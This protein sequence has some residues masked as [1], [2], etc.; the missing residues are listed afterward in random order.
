MRHMNGHDATRAYEGCRLPVAKDTMARNFANTYPF[1][2]IRKA[3][4]TP[5]S[6][7]SNAFRIIKNGFVLVKL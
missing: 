3:L 1:F 7:L 4:E 5:D 6:H 2:M